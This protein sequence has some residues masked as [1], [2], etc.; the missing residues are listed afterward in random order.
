MRDLCAAEA[1]ASFERDFEAAAQPGGVLFETI[2]RRK[3][4][5]PFP[6]EI[7]ARTIDIGGQPY[8]QSFIRDIGARKLAEEK[9]QQ[10]LRELRQ[11]YEATLDREGRVAELKAEVNALDRRLG[12][13]P[14][15]PSQDS[16][17]TEPPE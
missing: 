7:S 6:A 11:W 13:P 8:R 9:N 4:G 5:S 10:Q 12:E 15:Y 17:G 1:R 2:H 16:A 3:D 14:R